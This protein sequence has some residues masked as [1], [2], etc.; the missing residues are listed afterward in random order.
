MP[1]SRR[2]QLQL[3]IE[4]QRNEVADDVTALFAVVAPILEGLL[5]GLKGDV[6]A[7][8]GGRENVKLKMLNR[9]RRPGD[10]DVGI[11]FEYAVHDA[12]Q[13]NDPLVTERI[14]D[15]LRLCSVPGDDLTSLLFGA[16]KT[17]SQQIIATANDVL[18]DESSLLYGARGRPVKLK[19]HISGIAEAF[20]RPAARARLPQSVSGIWRADLFLG[21]R[22]EQKWVGTTVK[23]QA[24]DLKP[25]K[26][27]RV[28]IHPLREGESDL[29]RKEGN[30][31][32]CPLLHDASFM[33]LFY[34]AWI[35]VQLFLL[36]DA[37]VPKENALP[38][39]PRRFVAR[40]LAERREVPVV[41]VA[42]LLRGL[43]QP[44]LLETLPSDTDIEVT[45]GDEVGVE[46]VV[47][48]IAR[49]VGG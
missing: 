34:R 5:Y 32:L 8:V 4:R 37:N 43:G 26:G 15:A 31:V 28:G 20:R 47:A 49:S 44:E 11:C 18:T 42:E 6:V 13:R 7:E 2:E 22:D 46:A 38:E 17:G 9:L 39:G 40:E 10:G 16:E 3:R 45:R 41:E 30:L 21:M 14:F 24:R 1:A 27:L 12:V 35:L 29:P 36:A 48:P 25:D 19:R 33:E 23:I